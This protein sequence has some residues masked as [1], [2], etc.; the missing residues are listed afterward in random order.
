MAQTLRY[1]YGPNHFEPPAPEREERREMIFRNPNPGYVGFWRRLLAYLIDG[2]ILSVADGVLP[3]PDFSQRLLDLL[4]FVILP[5]TAWQGTIGKLA[6]GAKIVEENGERISI[7]RSVGRY[8]AQFLSA[9]L[10]FIGFIMIAFSA[11]K[12]GLHDWICDT[13]VV[14]RDSEL[15]P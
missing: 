14:N 12:R 1:Q 2:L 8:L 10:L 15:Y 6:V 13:F 5:A 3:L 11:E 4:Y 7:L 9:L